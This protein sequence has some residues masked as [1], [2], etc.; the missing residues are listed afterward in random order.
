[1]GL[2]QHIKENL[3]QWKDFVKQP[4]AMKAPVPKPYENIKSFNRLFLVRGFMPEKVMKE[5]SN[6]T[7]LEMGTFYE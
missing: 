3:Q 5:F 6:Y 1:M 7:G 2:S 4:N